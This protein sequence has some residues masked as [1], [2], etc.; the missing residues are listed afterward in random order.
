MDMFER[1]VREAFENRLPL[2]E[3]DGH[4]ILKKLKEGAIEKFQGAVM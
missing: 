1:G 4:D 3:A 2:G